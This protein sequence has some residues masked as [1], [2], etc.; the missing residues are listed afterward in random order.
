MP[1]SYRG[2]Y[3]RDNYNETEIGQLYAQEVKKLINNAINKN[4]RIAAF[5]SESMVSCGGQV[6]L[7]PGYLRTVYE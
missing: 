6:V 5:I 1:C 2:M 4:R 3:T 7:P